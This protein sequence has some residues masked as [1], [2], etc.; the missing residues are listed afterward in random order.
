MSQQNAQRAPALPRRGRERARACLLQLPQDGTKNRGV[1][2]QAGRAWQ[3]SVFSVPDLWQL[4]FLPASAPL[5]LSARLS[6]SRA[7]DVPPVTSSG[8]EPVPSP[9]SVS[10]GSGKPFCQ[11]EGHCTPL[12][13]Q[14]GDPPERPR[15]LLCYQGCAPSDAQSPLLTRFSFN[16]TAD[17]LR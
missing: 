2:H 8:C 6:S 13:N 7:H 3:I 17:L 9:C 1:C 16:F 14:G 11:A 15:S 10:R 12:E 5:L 4:F